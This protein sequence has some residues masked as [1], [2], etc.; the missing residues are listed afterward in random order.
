MVDDKK[1]N[2]GLIFFEVMILYYYV[3]NVCNVYHFSLSENGKSPSAI[4]S[5]HV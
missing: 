3:L 4:N 5:S 1:F 2:S